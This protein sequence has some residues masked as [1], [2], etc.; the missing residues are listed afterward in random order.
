MLP[1]LPTWGHLARKGGAT[2]H[3]FSLA[4]LASARINSELR[5]GT[6][7]VLRQTALRC[8]VCILLPL[9]MNEIAEALFRMNEYSEY[10][11]SQ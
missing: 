11:S 9:L 4:N 5:M 10:S 8:N 6:S 3:H 1:L 2:F 7:K